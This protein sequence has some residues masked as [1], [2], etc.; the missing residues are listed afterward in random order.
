MS[1]K[2]HAGAITKLF[3]NVTCLNWT[4]SVKWFSVNWFRSIDF[5]Q[6]I[7][8]HLIFGQMTFGQMIF[9]QMISVKWFSVKWFSVNW[10]SVKWFSVKWSYSV[11]EL[12]I[13]LWKCESILSLN[14]WKQ[15]PN[16]R[17]VVK[18]WIPN[19]AKHIVYSEWTD[20]IENNWIL[21]LDK[22]L[23]QCLSNA[24]NGRL[25][26]EPFLNPFWTLYENFAKTIKLWRLLLMMKL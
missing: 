3:L 1:H 23:I 6:M 19:I 12:V 20:S 18:N 4:I 9:G 5:G 11:S 7:F 21:F 17:V 14:F 13:A 26:K 2:E 24:M 22:R 25:L 8:G 16:I 15:M 10:F